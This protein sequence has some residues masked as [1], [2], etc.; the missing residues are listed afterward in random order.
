M[1]PAQIRK[2]NPIEIASMDTANS[3]FGEVTRPGDADQLTIMFDT[4]L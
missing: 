1:H 4:I 3:S 2:M